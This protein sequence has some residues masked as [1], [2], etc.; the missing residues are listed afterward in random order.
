M[1]SLKQVLLALEREIL[2]GKT[3]LSI[4]K[5]LLATATE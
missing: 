2:F 3:Y 5:G 4:G 1:P